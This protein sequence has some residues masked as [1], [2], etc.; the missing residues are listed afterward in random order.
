M[1]TLYIDLAMDLHPYLGL[2]L[3]RPRIRL[4]LVLGLG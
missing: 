1:L 2:G 3:V 4:E